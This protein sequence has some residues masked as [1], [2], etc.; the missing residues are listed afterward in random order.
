MKEPYRSEFMEY[1]KGCQD[2]RKLL[3]EAFPWFMDVAKSTC[4]LKKK[5]NVEGTAFSY[6][7]QTVEDVILED[8]RRYFLS[9]QDRKRENLYTLQ[10]LIF[11]G[12]QLIPSELA[13]FDSDIT[14]ASNIMRK[15][16]IGRISIWN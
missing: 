9:L 3:L 5:G 7:L 4:A 16:M 13:D 2:A 1:A 11:D 6:L 14:R 10:A 12:L 8:V 15:N